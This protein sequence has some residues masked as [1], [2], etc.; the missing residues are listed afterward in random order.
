MP[1]SLRTRLSDATGQLL[2][3]LHGRGLSFQQPRSRASRRI[4]ILSFHR[5]SRLRPDHW[6]T[7]SPEVFE[8][9]MREVQRRFRIVSLAEVDRLLAAG[10]DVEPT[11]A[12]SFDDAYGCNHTFAVP[13]LRELGIPATFFVSSAFVD[14]S[15]PFPHDLRR[16]FH[17]IPSF[18]SAQLRDMADD[19]LFEIGSHSVSHID[20]SARPP[21]PTIEQ[22]LVESRRALEAI[23]GRP[24]RRF[25]VPFGSRAH[26]TPEVI[27]AARELGYQRLYSFFGGSNLIAPDGR[28][29]F[30]LNRLGPVHFTPSYVFAMC[31]GYEGRQAFSPRR[32]SASPHAPD[33]QPSGF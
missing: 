9:L 12:V 27:A 10:A 5:V 25:A 23:T 13:V 1:D 22:E 20:F 24:V 11:T 15:T 4:P 30:V 19:P 2:A 8:Q 14:S 17:D 3:W 29:A 6:M 28:L 32:R 16:G 33:F 7:V 31:D 26:F 21:A 18:T